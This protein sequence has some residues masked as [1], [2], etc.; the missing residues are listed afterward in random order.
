MP[1]ARA[2]AV[3]SGCMSSS[4]L[5]RGPLLFAPRFCGGAGAGPPLAKAPLFGLALKPGVCGGARVN[6]RAGEAAHAAKPGHGRGRGGARGCWTW[7]RGR[8]GCGGA[9]RGIAGAGRGPAAGA[10]GRGDDGG[11]GGSTRPWPARHCC[12]WSSA[13]CGPSAGI[14]ASVSKRVLQAGQIMT[15]IAI[16]TSQS[17]RIYLDWQPGPMPL[18]KSIDTG[19]RVPHKDAS[20]AEC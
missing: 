20:W 19:Q 5:N 11:L 15:V 12:I 2:G 17:G 4:V 6:W 16:G 10:R 8:R 3:R 18:P 9:G 13:L 14:T 1:A 7:R